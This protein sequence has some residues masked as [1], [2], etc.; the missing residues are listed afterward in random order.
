MCGTGEHRLVIAVALVHQ[1][2]LQASNAE[3]GGRLRNPAVS[4]AP[5]MLRIAVGMWG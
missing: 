3:A 2:M 4:P 5:A 1:P